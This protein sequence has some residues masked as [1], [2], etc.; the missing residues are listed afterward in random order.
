MRFLDNAATRV[1]LV[2]AVATGLTYWLGEHHAG[3]PLGTTE[4]WLIF[5]LA[6]VKGWLVVDVFMGLRQAP[7]FWRWLLLGWLAVV[8]LVLA[9]LVVFTR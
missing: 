7:R 1:W 6:G 9:S 3:H 2:L 5:G 8:A 4:V